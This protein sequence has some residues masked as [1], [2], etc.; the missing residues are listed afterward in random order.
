MKIV[1]PHFFVPDAQD[2]SASITKLVGR[3]G[4]KRLT[5]EQIPD[6]WRNVKAEL[7][8]LKLVTLLPAGETDERHEDAQEDEGSLGAWDSQQDQES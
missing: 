4:E 3:Y 8:R 5:E 7:T 2:L 6:F 1:T